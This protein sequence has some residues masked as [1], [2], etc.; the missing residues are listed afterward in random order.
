MREQY[1]PDLIERFPE[2]FDGVD[3]TDSYF[4]ESRELDAY[5]AFR[6][7]EEEYEKTERE[8]QLDE[9]LNGRR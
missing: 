9:C 1:I 5:D 3:L 2:G 7:M 4:P 6:L 8:W